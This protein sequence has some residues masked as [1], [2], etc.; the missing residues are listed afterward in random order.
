MASAVS[1]FLATSSFAQGDSVTILARVI[2]Q[3]SGLPVSNATVEIV[4]GGPQA[5]TLNSGPSDA[6][7]WAEATWNTQAPNKKGQG[8]TPSG[9][10]TATTTNVTATGYHWDGVTTS[11]AFGI[12]LDDQ[13]N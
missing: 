13:L 9:S 4:I 6:E 5:A 2:D 10:Y 1:P 11:A 8:G 3:V 7:G 12:Q